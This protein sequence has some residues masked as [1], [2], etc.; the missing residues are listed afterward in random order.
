MMAT[1][2][3]WRALHFDYGRITL[4]E[5]LAPPYDVITREDQEALYRLSPYNAVRLILG[6]DEPGDTPL[7]NRYTRAKEFL[8]RWL[9][10]GILVRDENLCFYLYEQAFSDPGSGEKNVRRSI[11]ALLKLEDFKRGIVLPHERTYARPKE[12]RLNLLN[13]TDTN[14][15]PVF[16]LYH[17]EGGTVST[18]LS[19]CFSR[20]P[21]AQAKDR[22]QIEHRI[23]RLEGELEIRGLTEAFRDKTI[24]LADGHHRYE[25]AL[26][27]RNQKRNESPEAESGRTAEASPCDY[28]LVSLVDREAPGLVVLPT[29]R[30]I[31][32]LPNFS[33]AVLL[34]RLEPYFEL[35]PLPTKQLL[36]RLGNLPKTDKGFGVHLG[37]DQTYLAKLKSLSLVESMAPL[38]RSQAWKELEVSILSYAVLE[39]LLGVPEERWEDCL[40]YTRSAEEAC[41]RVDRGECAA[42]FILRSIPVAEIQKVCEQQDLLP[43]KSTFFYPKLASGLVFYEH[44]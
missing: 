42:A 11:F 39:P 28:V 24:L 20:A 1:I 29:H 13:E 43:P 37:S 12:D 19:R 5:V 14:L 17:D 25:T 38:A 34:K 6:K 32:N 4:S 15:S 10:D 31:K 16:G 30:L 35:S 2:K 18:L 41:A 21:L 3:P 7:N 8:N 27:H 26:S 23:W 22:E 40:A 9:Q 36:T 44:R 33:P